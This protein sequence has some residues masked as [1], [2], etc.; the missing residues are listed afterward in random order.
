MEKITQVRPVSE[1]PW[2]GMFEVRLNGENYGWYATQAEAEQIAN[3]LE[4]D[5]RRGRLWN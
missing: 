4:N 5:N 2:A 3:S 1:G